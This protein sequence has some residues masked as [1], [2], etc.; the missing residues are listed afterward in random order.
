MQAALVIG[1]G[2]PLRSD[3]G[4]GALLAEQAAVI[5]A[6]DAQGPVAV[7]SVQQLTPE[8]AAELAALEAVLFI[9]AWEA[10]EGL[11][12]ALIPLRPQPARL[13]SHRLEPCALLGLAQAL[14]GRAPRA[15]LLRV[16]AQ[17]FG[18]GISLSSSLQQ[19]LPKARVL[20]KQWLRE[21]HA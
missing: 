11:E 9:D 1:I 21:L 7:R 14:Y 5:T 17:A 12:P 8:L 4:A 6:A 2:N 10:P 16:P 19:A 18:H 15:H 13:Q 3:D 20:L